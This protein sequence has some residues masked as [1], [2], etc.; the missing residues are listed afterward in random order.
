MRGRNSPALAFLSV[1]LYTIAALRFMRFCDN[2]DEGSVQYVTQR[3]S[4]RR[5]SNEGRVRLSAWRRLDL[6]LLTFP[7]P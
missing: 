6:N 4:E 7:V 1:H 2:A 5:N 3:S